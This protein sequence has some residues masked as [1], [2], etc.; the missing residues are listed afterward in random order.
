MDGHGHNGTIVVKV[1]MI[2]VLV[3]IM[4]VNSDGNDVYGELPN[5][6]IT[7][8]G[9]TLKALTRMSTLSHL[10]MHGR[11]NITPAVKKKF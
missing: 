4:L 3:M 7:F 2:L 10:S 6:S 8:C 11:M 1:V 9:G 5:V